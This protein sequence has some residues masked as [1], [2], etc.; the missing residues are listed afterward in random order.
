MGSF[1]VGDKVRPNLENWLSSEFDQWIKPWDSPI[2]EI[3]EPPFELDESKVD[4]RW[5]GGRYF[6]TENELILVDDK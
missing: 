4:V 2:G 6:Q 1:K 5:P 3:V